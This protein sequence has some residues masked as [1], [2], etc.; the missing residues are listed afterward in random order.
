MFP[1]DLTLITGNSSLLSAVEM[2]LLSRRPLSPSLHGF[3]LSFPQLSPPV[4]KVLSAFE[5]LIS[6]FPQLWE[7]TSSLHSNLIL[8][9]EKYH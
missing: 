2:N 7:R 8:H 9:C 6:S 1:V 4:P 3:M 5:I